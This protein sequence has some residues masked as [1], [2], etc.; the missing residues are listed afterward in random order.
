MRRFTQAVISFGAAVLGLAVA[1][2]ALPVPWSN[3]SGTVPGLF[4]WSNG[5]S[6]NG[7]FGSPIVSGT[8]FTFFPTNF[9]AVS[10]NGVA[11]TTSDRLSFQIDVAPGAPDFEAVRV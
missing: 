2:N 10:S 11:Q 3:P 6:D 5:Q 9:R 4:S 8:S 7:L 1:A